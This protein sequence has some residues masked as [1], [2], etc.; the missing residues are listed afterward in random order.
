VINTLVD[1][2]ILLIFVV[3]AF[4]A[5]VG[6]VKVKGISL[7]PAGA[8]F[9]GLA[10]SA[11]DDRLAIPEVIGTM[12]LALFT[13]T[14]GLSSGPAFFSSLRAQVRTIAFVSVM[15]LVAAALSQALGAAFGFDDGLTAGLFAGSLTNTPALAAARE[16]LHGST[17]PVVAYS[18]TYPIGVIGVIVATA[19]ALRLG[20]RSPNADD[21]YAPVDLVTNT[22]QVR[23]EV[24]ADLGEL[25]HRFAGAAVFT[26]VERDGIQVVP[27]DDFVVQ[28]GDL[29]SVTSPQLVLDEV[30]QVLGMH[31]AG[32][33]SDDR[34]RLDLR[35][36]VVSDRRLTGRRLGDL[37]LHG[38]FGAVATRLRRG[39]VDLLAHDDVTLLP[40]DRL[41]VVAPRERLGEITAFL[42]D[43][44]RRIGEIDAVGFMVGISLGLALGLISIPLFGSGHF[45]LGTAG[46]P[47]V[48]GL[49]VGHLE[50]TGPV[51]WQP[52]Y[53]AN[54]AIRQL[55][56]ILFLGT[57]GSRSGG[58]LIDAM[59]SAQ[60]AKLAV[61]GLVVIAI[62]AGCTVV[63]GRRLIGLGGARMA[64]AL[65]AM[66]TQPAV[67]AFANEQTSDERVGTTYALV[68]PVAMLLK[69]L[70][71]QVLVLL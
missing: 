47:L 55:G 35:R 46:G 11:I 50:R 62:A 6:A 21:T 71:A 20:R 65:A 67:L 29:V 57:V 59:S 5:A 42:G 22:V 49:V 13:Y 31:V 2:P 38:R 25:A 45:A 64:G 10:L 69:I 56:T 39:D 36:I 34:S 43:S 16:A 53:G 33:L 40:G 48:V 17:E 14:I 18:V 30:E 37:D 66:E 61:A 12:G 15:L 1:H 28:P 63:V 52:P 9:A 3:L 70:L 19:W 58:A 51:V 44:E 8:L 68:F 7:G 23:A 32:K 4:G 27:G 60:G 54:L 26:R 41:R 24:H